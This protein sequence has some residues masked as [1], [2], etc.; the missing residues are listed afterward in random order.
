[1]YDYY[2]IRV[3]FCFIHSIYYLVNVYSK[4]Q[5]KEINDYHLVTSNTDCHLLKINF[6]CH[7]G[8]SI[9]ADNPTPG[10]H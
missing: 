4:I 5:V 8:I 10:K 6:S 1:M 3:F 2:L 7:N 9:H